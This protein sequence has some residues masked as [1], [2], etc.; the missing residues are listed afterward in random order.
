MPDQTEAPSPETLIARAEALIPMIRAQAAEAEARG[1]FSDELLEQFREAGFYRMFLPK[2]FGGYES[3][4]ETFLEVAYR[5]GCGD[6]GT[7]WC[8]TLS[9]SHV[10]IVASMLGEQ[11][12]RELIEPHGELRSPHRAPPGGKA[13]KV[14]GGYRIS[15]KWRFSSGVP[16]STHF[17]ANTI[18]APED[19]EPVEFS[20]I[21][22]VENVTIL[23]D[24]GGG[25]GIGVQASG[26]NTV[27]IAEPVFVPEHHVIY[28]DLLFGQDRDWAGGTPG[29]RLHGNGHYLGVY[30]GFYH[31]CFAA[32]FAGGAQAAV[33]ELRE[34]AG[35]TQALFSPPGVLMRDNG[36]VQRALGRA[37]AKADAA[38]AIMTAG[39]RASDALLDRWAATKQ[40]ITK[41]ETMQLWALGRQ[42]ALLACE[43]VQIAFQAAG[44]SAVSKSSPLQRIVRDCEVYLGHA[45]SQPI[46]DMARGQAEL[47]VEIMFGP[48]DKPK[49]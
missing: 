3:T 2:M 12:Q 45:S 31:L 18:W 33:D 41:A 29:T 7:A 42:A 49:A 25:K 19:G 34:L 27:E 14:E 47:G 38:H 28:D 1:H 21:T 17:M 10:A 36:D 24:W 46:I 23:D 35:R 22:P 44:P 11:A 43:A 48:P 26:S 5:V 4:H 9:A 20:F 30:G 15:G 32:I 37:A 39:A 13:E 8:Y 6:P 16:V 40:P